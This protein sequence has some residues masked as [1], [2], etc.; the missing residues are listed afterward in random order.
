[1]DKGWPVV[2]TWCSGW[3]GRGENTCLDESDKNKKMCDTY[4]QR[5]LQ[6][7]E[8]Q[9]GKVRQSTSK[10]KTRMGVHGQRMVGAQSCVLDNII[11][12]CV[13]VYVLVLLSFL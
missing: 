11:T 12:R 5:Y 9:A 8:R 7:S 6:A 3:I 2:P 13:Y 10:A 4:Q 1:M